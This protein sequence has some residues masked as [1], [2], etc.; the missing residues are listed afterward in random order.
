LYTF[1]KNFKLDL[2]LTINTIKVLEQEGLLFFNES[3]FIPST[4]Q[5]TTDKS[6]LEF[7]EKSHPNLEPIIKCLLRSYTGIYDHPTPIFEKQIAKIIRTTDANVIE[8]LH[9]LHRLQ[10][11]DYIPQKNTPQIFF[12]TN[13]A[14]AK[15]LNIRQDNYLKR[16]ASFQ[17]R[18]NTMQQYIHL[19]NACRS[20]FMAAYF[21]DNQVRSCGIC[22]NCLAKKKIALSTEVILQLEQAI[23]SLARKLP[24]ISV[25][26]LLQNIDG[27]DTE[28]KWSVIQLLEEEKKI[29]IGINQQVQV[30]I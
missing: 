3:V 26:E 14:S 8:Q 28:K 4:V 27:F 13:R 30:L 9:Q 17:K 16:K 25:E 19:D 22:D 21:G 10:I 6:S 29:I 23:L 7:L 5:F 15:Y 24:N 2:I 18:V 12:T 11:I 1:I 20:V